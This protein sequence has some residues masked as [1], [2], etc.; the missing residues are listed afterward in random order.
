MRKAA[1]VCLAALSCAAAEPL[2]R[3]AGF[4][5]PDAKGG[6]EGWSLY[7]NGEWSVNPKRSSFCSIASRR[8]TLPRKTACPALLFDRV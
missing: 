6:A 7:K 3:N 2:P 4:E 1:I 5:V 8:L